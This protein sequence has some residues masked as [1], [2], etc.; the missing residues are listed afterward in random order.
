MTLAIFAMAGSAVLFEVPRA[1]VS[2]QTFTA[3]NAKISSATIDARTLRRKDPTNL[4]RISCLREA[5]RAL[6]TIS[7][8]ACQSIL[9]TDSLT[10]REY[11]AG[12]FPD[13]PLCHA[14]QEKPR[15]SSSRVRA[16]HNQVGVQR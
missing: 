5:L 4:S 13:H 2:A 10:D 12:G 9:A 1:R 15:N 14:A 11:R 6:G 3:P 16:H 8:P 7:R